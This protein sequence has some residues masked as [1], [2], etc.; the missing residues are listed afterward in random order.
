M[1]FTARTVYNELTD[2]LMGRQANSPSGGGLPVEQTGPH[3]LKANSVEERD[4][5]VLQTQQNQHFRAQMMQLFQSES[6]KRLYF[7][8]TRLEQ[9]RDYEAMEDYPDIARALD[10]LAEEA[11][12]GSITG[13]ALNIY[14]DN[15]QTKAVLQDL[16]YNTLDIPVQLPFWARCMIKHGDCFLYHPLAAGRGILG[17]RILS[18]IDTERQE[19]VVNDE[20]TVRFRYT[21]GTGHVH[22]YTLWQVSHFRMLGN[23]R[24]LP[25]GTSLLYRVRR[26]YKMLV[27]AKDAVL[28][29]RLT[30]A[31]ERRVHK[32]YTGN[33]NPNDVP[34]YLE[35]VANSHKKA[36]LIDPRTGDFDWTYQPA[37]MDM[38]YYT[39]VSSES[40]GTQIDT[41]PG[42][43]N[44]DALGDI[45]MLE[46]DLFGGLGIPMSFIKFSSD[47]GGSSGDGKSMSMLDIRLAR[48]V[49]RIQ[50][51]LL[52][53]LNKMAIVH[54]HLLGGDFQEETDNFTLTL[55]SPSVQLE[56]QQEELRSSKLDNFTKAVTPGPNGLAAMSYAEGMKEI[57]GKSEQHI[58]QSLFD[59]F[60]EAKIAAEIKS[61]P[62][63][64]PSSRLYDP[65]IRFAQAGKKGAPNTSSQ[66]GADGMGGG[67]AGDMG[68]MSALPGGGD[69]FPAGP[70]AGGD[71]GA[72][73]PPPGPLNE[74]TMRAGLRLL[75]IAQRL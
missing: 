27:M 1:A 51:A 24:R 55:N 58:K 25:Y 71:A 2:L 20:P 75:E 15:E 39:G 11:T 10:L 22:E 34:A 61:A 31:P 56:L 49:N 65:L 50:Q 23:E 72:P 13:K 33:I 19:T 67:M 62:E 5:L 9:Y 63:L 64:L 17:A 69:G 46:A 38:D 7:E 29:Y 6:N 30:R 18:T 14:S 43:Q 47:S 59:Q 28:V 12:M 45:S 4:T 48:L 8:G 3:I 41:L 57:L 52:G 53:E 68:A 37:T 35:A 16:F 21:T 40:A 54:L 26:T 66:G 42:A 44:L 36:R 70:E 73:P 32:I 60:T 74:Q